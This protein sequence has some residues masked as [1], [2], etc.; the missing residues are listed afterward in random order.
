MI[1]LQTKNPNQGPWNGKCWHIFMGIWSSLQPF[2]IFYRP[3]V[4]YVVILV[5][6][7]CLVCTLHQAKSC[8][9]AH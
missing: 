4:Q 3:L 7:S 1:Y 9:P 6:F 2:D 5:Y 8:N